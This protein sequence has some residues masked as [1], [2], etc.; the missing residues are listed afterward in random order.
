[1]NTLHE[2]FESA[3]LYT[4]MYLVALALITLACDGLYWHW[5][6]P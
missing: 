2:K 5:L 3:V 4:L 6:R 1:M